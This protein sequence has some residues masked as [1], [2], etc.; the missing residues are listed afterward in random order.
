MPKT[1]WGSSCNEAYKLTITHESVF[2]YKDCYQNNF[3]VFLCFRFEYDLYR[4]LSVLIED[5][6]KRIERCKLMDFYE[7]LDEPNLVYQAFH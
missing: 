2:L 3:C 1:G 6:E 5:L 7:F 4:Y